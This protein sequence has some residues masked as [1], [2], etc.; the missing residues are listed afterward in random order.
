MLGRLEQLAAK[1]P[2]VPLP[3]LAHRFDQLGIGRV[4]REDGLV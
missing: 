2:E 4:G 3:D 1:G